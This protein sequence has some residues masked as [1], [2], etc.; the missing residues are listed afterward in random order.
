MNHQPNREIDP[1]QYPTL[2]KY[3]PKMIWTAVEKL[4]TQYPD[5]TEEQCLLNLEM[6]MQ[7]IELMSQG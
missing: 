2:A 1:I 6:D 3:D 7:Q 5:M 4:Q